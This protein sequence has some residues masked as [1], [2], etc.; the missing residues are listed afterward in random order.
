MK[1]RSPVPGV[2]AAILTAALLCTALVEGGWLVWLPVL[3]A[4]AVVGLIGSP[5]PRP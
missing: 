1:K 3:L 4:L 2:V 5:A